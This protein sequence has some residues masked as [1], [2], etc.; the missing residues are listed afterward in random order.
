MCAYTHTCTHDF[1]G[2]QDH[3][4]SFHSRVLAITSVFLSIPSCQKHTEPVS[5]HSASFDNNSIY[6]KAAGAVTE[7]KMQGLPTEGKIMPKDKKHGLLPLAQPC[8]ILNT[9]ISI[10]RCNCPYVRK[11]CLQGEQSTKNAPTGGVVSPPPLRVSLGDSSGLKAPEPLLTP[12]LKPRPR[13]PASA[14]SPCPMMVMGVSLK[15]CR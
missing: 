1:C 13:S 9:S 11:I 8:C 12:I 5:T 7:E 6:L 3:S 14:Q 15:Q 10:A 2:R 4:A